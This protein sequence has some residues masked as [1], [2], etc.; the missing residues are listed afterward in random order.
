[1]PNYI[2]WGGPI[3]VNTQTAGDQWRASTIGLADGGFLVVWQ[4][5]STT[6]DGSLG[7]IKGQRYGATGNPVGGEFLVN[8]ATVGNQLNVSAA[9]LQSGGYVLTWETT[10]AAQD[11]SGTAVKA[12]LFD[13]GGARVGPE[14]LVNSLTY[15]DQQAPSVAALASGGFVIA[16]HTTDTAQDGAGWAVK[17]QRFDAAG[18]K[19]GSEFLVNTVVFGSQNNI[20]IAGLSN[21]GF[22]VTWQTGSGATANIYARNYAPDGTALGAQFQVST[23]YG[24]QVD[25]RVAALTGG[26]FVVTWWTGLGIH[27]AMYDSGGT[28]IGE[29]F[30]VS[31]NS[32]AGRPDVAPLNDGGFLVS[33]NYAGSSTGIRSQRFDA[34]GQRVGT[35]Q[36]V[37]TEANTSL[38]NAAVTAL[39]GGGYAVIWDQSALSGG[40][41]GNDIRAQRYLPDTT[42][43]SAPELGA[44]TLALSRPENATAVA[45][46]AAVDDNGPGPLAYSISGGADASL[47]FIDAATGALSFIGKPD[48]ETPADVDHNNV[49]EVIVR[50]SDGALA[51]TQAVSITVTNVNDAPVITSNGGT[52]SASISLLENGTAV[53]TVRATDAENSPIT[54][55]ISGGN[56][57]TRFTINPTTGVLSFIAPPDFEAPADSDHNNQYLVNVQASDGSLTA[58]QLLFVTVTNVNEAPV[59]GSNGGG[60]TAILT[61]AENGTAVTTVTAADP[62]KTALTYSISGGADAVRF[63]INATTGILTFLAAPNYEAPT[64][65]NRDNVYQVTVRASDGTLVDTQA[66]SITVTN[67]N[68]A[69]VIGSNGG[70]D[71]AALTVAEN[72]VAV[73]TVAA[74][75]PENAAVTYSISGGADAARFA[76]NGS[77]GVLT[78]VAAP[79]FEAPAD[80]DAN[81]VYL[82]NVRASDGVLA[83]TQA[84]SVTVTNVN[85]APVI[86]SNGGGD[87]AALLVAENGSAVTSVLAA[88][89]EHAAVTYSIAGGAD[90]ARFA[91]DPSTGALSFVAAPD[92]EAPAD[93]DANNVYQVTVSAGD[94]TV[95]D[96]QTLSVTVTNVVEGVTITSG[97][98]G[99][100]SAYGLDENS[101]AVAT[102]S[103]V[104][105]EAGPVSYALAGGADAA[106]FAIDSSTGQLSFI[107]APDYEAP[108]DSNGDNFYDVLVSAGNGTF[109]DVQT[110]S[111]AVFDVADTPSEGVEKFFVGPPTDLHVG[112]FVP[113]PVTTDGGFIF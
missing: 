106:L 72:G 68:E 32:N 85:E 43:N 64:D 23:D 55:S 109:T 37:A 104:N 92:Y 45:T 103:A 73:T 3:A 34:A 35:E 29:E 28:K 82:V 25:G 100:W 87:T 1:M 15:L 95:T 98:G 7:A 17:A 77:T 86:G 39:A 79:N 24:S 50:A 102:V 105:G 6:A 71:T 61:L 81:N 62:E 40:G 46:L 18:A 108:A 75:D 21:G 27:G 14:F 5:N 36:L 78:F 4:T 56:D 76:I 97:G 91:I 42:V 8:T 2:R 30:Y 107:S 33:W 70:G 60:D 74:S 67:V 59:I 31:S 99:D 83:D 41:T 54:Y 11:G 65:S 63:A 88:D 22:V 80:F 9:T 52:A 44:P 49:Y 47:F 90:A 57:S 53:S 19:V 110:L 101:L 58:T 20:D 113:I 48:F 69:P 93:A 111:V 51:D 26:G 96:T 66:L 112:P 38:G 13:A 12:Q 89:P 94:G 16:W 10:D 84:L